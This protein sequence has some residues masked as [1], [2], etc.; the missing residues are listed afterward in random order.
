MCRI[1]SSRFIFLLF[2]AFHSIQANAWISAS[3]TSSLYYT[4]A[5]DGKF[6]PTMQVMWRAE[7]PSLHFVT[8]SRKE[9]VASVQAQITFT[10]EGGTILYDMFTINTLPQKNVAGLAGIAV[11]GQQMYVLEKA[12][13]GRVRMR[14]QLT[15][16]N[17]TASKYSVTDSTDYETETDKPFFGS[18][19]L[20]GGSDS[21]RSIEVLPG[22]FAGTE[23]RVLHYSADL[24]HVDDATVAPTRFPLVITTQLSR[25]LG[26]AFMPDFTHTD[27]IAA[28]MRARAYGSMPIGR[29]TSGN[30]YI[31]VSAADKD[32]FIIATRRLFFQR[33]NQHPDKEEKKAATMKQILNDTGMERVTVVNMD[34]TFLNKYTP[35]QLRAILKMLLPV[36]DPMQT[37]TINGF[38]KKPE[39]MYIKYFIYNYFEALKPGDAAGAWKAY[40]EKVTTV[41][42][43]YTA[44]GNAG[45]ET[46]RGFIW[47]RYGPPTDIITVSGEA[48][49]KPYEIW[50]YNQLTQ[51]SNKKELTNSLF[52]FYRQS[53]NMSDYQLLHC[54]VPGETVNPGWRNYLYTNN[55][56]A[57]DGFSLNTR[58]EQY[59]EN[60]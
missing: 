15:D 8:N 42:K 46:D 49:T 41:N 3:V 21:V 32:G 43:K 20:N 59:F 16:M 57:T 9:I 7:P 10:D 23:R 33:L 52:L 30:Y 27:T 45:Y 2:L 4:K 48:G 60:R 47:L 34:K 25:K 28:G 5:A 51:F 14:F 38:L 22:N 1:V 13:G 24:Y 17:D 56:A 55:R 11:G 40:S 35:S 36:A 53:Q 6:V 58:A 26:D 39:E 37:N 31:N 29:L 54:T 12:R 18:I 50:Q 19:R 44:N